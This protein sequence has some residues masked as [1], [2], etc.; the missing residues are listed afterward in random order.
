MNFTYPLIDNITDDLPPGFYRVDH[1]PYHDGAGLSSSDIKNALV[2]YGY[3]RHK[4]DAEDE[5]TPAMEFG[6]AF[7][8]AILE[9]EL[10]ASRYVVMPNFTLTHGHANSTIHKVAKSDWLAKHDGL[11]II[12]TENKDLLDTLSDNVRSHPRWKDL[13]HCTPEVAAIG[14]L[15]DY[16]GLV[17]CKPDMLG[18]AIIDFKTTQCAAKW[19]FQMDV[20]KFLYHVSAAFYQDIV[21]SVTGE[22]LPFVHVAVEKKPPYGVAFY[23][24]SDEYL[25]DG[26]KLYRAGLKRIA[27]WAG[28]PLEKKILHYGESIQVLRPTARTMYRTKD[29]IEA[30]ENDT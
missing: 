1:D 8:M 12:K 21:K 9:P 20:D 25:D 19:A 30:V 28:L 2:S 27:R 24:L 13:K 22:L 14:T 29:L 5:A 4:K 3:Y 10:F 26:R 17:K 6:R 23:T 11:E 16:A 18:S 15:P 7:H